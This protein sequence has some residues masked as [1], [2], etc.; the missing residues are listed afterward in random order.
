MWL[1]SG[2]NLKVNLTRAI[3]GC[4]MGYE[5]ELNDLSAVCS[6]SN[7]TGVAIK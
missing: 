4:D 7:W 3:D 1:N 2:Y 6:L 5:K